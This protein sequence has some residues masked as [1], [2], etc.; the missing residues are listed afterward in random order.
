[1]DLEFNLKIF[2]LGSL[3]GL[4]NFILLA[5]ISKRLLSGQASIATVFLIIFKYAFLGL[6]LYFLVKYAT[7]SLPW[8]VFGL[9]IFLISIIIYSLVAI[10]RTKTKKF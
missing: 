3:F 5:L 10:K 7:N 6:G 2:I 8:L 4:I 9:S 1:M